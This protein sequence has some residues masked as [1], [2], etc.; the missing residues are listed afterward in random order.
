MEIAWKT[1]IMTANGGPRLRSPSAGGLRDGVDP[2]VLIVCRGPMS[3]L[4]EDNIRFN[5]CSV[6]RKFRFKDTERRAWDIEEV[7]HE[8][9]I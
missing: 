3:V 5:G 2:S 6:G 4:E 1:M 9:D 7:E 8:Q